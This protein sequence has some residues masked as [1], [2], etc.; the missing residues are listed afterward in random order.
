MRKYSEE[1]Q[2]VTKV[3]LNAQLADE[4][5]GVNTK[6]DNKLT[7]VDNKLIEVDNT[8]AQIPDVVA[9]AAAMAI[10]LG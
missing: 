7:D 5:A 3:F 10:A 1:S 9:T 2:T 6:V 4:V 8:L